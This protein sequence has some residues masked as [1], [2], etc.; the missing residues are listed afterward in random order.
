MN[1]KTIV[2]L[3]YTSIFVGCIFHDDCFRDYSGRVNFSS[4]NKDVAVVVSKHYY[5]STLWKQFDTVKVN[6]NQN[7]YNIHW[8]DHYP[9]CTCH[10]DCP[11]GKGTMADSIRVQIINLSDR[12]KL[13]DTVFS[14]EDYN[15]NGDNIELP[16]ITIP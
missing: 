12:Q 15:F 16:T 5:A 2:T 10:N 13:S 8:A 14:C 7:T 11:G 1:I 6:K 3:L 4:T 9:Q